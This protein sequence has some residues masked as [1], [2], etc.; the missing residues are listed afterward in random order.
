MNYDKFISEHR[1]NPEKFREAWAFCL[2]NPWENPE[3]ADALNDT[4]YFKEA[5]ELAQLALEGKKTATAGDFSEYIR[6]NSPLPKVDGK[7]DIVLN[8][9]GEPVCAITTTKVYIV[10][11][12][13]VSAEHA[14][15]EGEGDLTLA[16]W[17]QVHE[18]FFRTF[19][20]FRPDMDIVCEEFQ[21]IS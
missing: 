19:G 6:E 13:E 20:T 12:N 8:S 11:F 18:E 7:Y 2:G 3:E 14:R 5:D 17:R 9:K 16:Y 10:K 21:V 15:K 4:E 1:L